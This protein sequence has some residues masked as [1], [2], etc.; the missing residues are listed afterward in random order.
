MN[1]SPFRNWRPKLF[2][3][4]HLI[5]PEG[6]SLDSVFGSYDDW[7]KFRPKAAAAPKSAP[8]NPGRKPIT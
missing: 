7:R 8:P 3:L 1:I 2:R 4:L 6:S 5:A